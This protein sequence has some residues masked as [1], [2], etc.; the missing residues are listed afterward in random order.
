V[1]ER[2]CETEWQIKASFHE[3]DREL[4]D[5]IAAAIAKVGAGAKQ[6]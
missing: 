1:A 4:L 3:F 6:V 5:Q 2:I